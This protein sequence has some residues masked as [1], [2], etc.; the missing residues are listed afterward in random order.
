V[1][2]QDG[3]A[4]TVSFANGLTLV[5]GNTAYQVAAVPSSRDPSRLTLGYNSGNGTTQ[6][7]ESQITGG[8]VGGVLKFRTESLD[9]ARNQLGQLALALADNFNQQHRAGFDINGNPGQD[10]FSFSGARAVS[11]TNNIGNAS[12]SVAYSNTSQVRAS[13]YRMEFD[14]TSWQVIRLADN[15]KVA[16]AAGTDINGNPILNF[17]GLQVSVAGTPQQSD[18]F[19]IKPVSDV[20]STLAMAISDSAQF[21]AAGAKNSGK[22]D[23]NNARQLLDLQNA[24]LVEGKATLSG[25]YAGL[26]SRVGNQ[27]ATAKVTNASQAVIVGQ[28]EAQQQS[29]SGVNLDEEYG[30]LLRFQQYYMANAQVIQTASSL[31]DALLNIR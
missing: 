30:D 31:F 17:D 4:Y 28:L 23:N 6:I 25:A 21:A 20:A 18:S 10:F 3:D 24:N 26:V 19:I 14:G 2:Q 29:I 22:G 8:S 13:D 16:T 11:N 27:T 15:T 5:Q 1:T 12:L 9:A 7:P